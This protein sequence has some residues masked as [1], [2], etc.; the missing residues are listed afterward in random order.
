MFMKKGVH[1][2]MNF[3]IIHTPF[4]MNT[5]NPYTFRT[6]V[7]ISEIRA[8]SHGVPSHLRSVHAISTIERKLGLTI[9]HGVRS[10]K[11]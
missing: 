7:G 5:C 9:A 4:I 11:S 1:C 3:L 8:G 10:P 6:L 2:I